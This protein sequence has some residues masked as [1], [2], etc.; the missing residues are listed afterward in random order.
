MGEERVFR[1]RLLMTRSATA[2][3]IFFFLA[4]AAA[5]VARPSG[6]IFAS[7]ILVLGSGLA[8]LVV[9]VR[10][11]RLKEVVVRPDA[12]S[13][14]SGQ[15]LAFADMS[16]VRDIR[17]K[18]GIGAWNEEDVLLIEM[19]SGATVRFGREW[20]DY[21]QLQRLVCARFEQ[22]RVLRGRI[23]DPE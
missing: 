13:I 5:A 17:E 20:Q 8:L 21:R 16:A 4:L 19:S 14:G 22:S 10:L 3:V 11:M 1:E 6:A 9:G 15:I 23:G 12:V 2:S 7:A 18:F